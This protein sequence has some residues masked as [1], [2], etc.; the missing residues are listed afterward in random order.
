R[1]RIANQCDKLLETFTQPC[2]SVHYKL[3]LEEKN[4][5]LRKSIFDCT[6]TASY[7]RRCEIIN[8]EIVF[9]DFQI[10]TTSYK[11]KLES[12]ALLSNIGGTMGI[13][14]GISTL[15]LY[16]LLEFII[17]LVHRLQRK[18]RQEKK[19]IYR[20]S[21]RKEYPFTTPRRVYKRTKVHKVNAY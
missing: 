4:I 5:L 3:K 2:D 11:P 1:I 9:N 8:V 7:T 6:K 14:L 10:R 20:N 15:S 17:D 13:Y 12:L 21:N 19:V 18:R 16:S